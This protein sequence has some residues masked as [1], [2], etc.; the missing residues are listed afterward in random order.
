VESI[1][2]LAWLSLVR[3][4]PGREVDAI[5]Y[6]VSLE[7]TI[8]VYDREGSTP[9]NANEILE[10]HLDAVMDELVRL[11]AG[12]P[13]IELDLSDCR[14]RFAILVEADDEAPAVGKASPTLRS[15]IHAAGG[16][17]PGRPETD[18]PAWGIERVRLTIEA[19]ELLAA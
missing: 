16:S 4:G 7:G 2:C 13:D 18:Q 17:T 6:V 8:A 19:V 15:A 11:D 5:H 9:A 12:D 3:L 10:A 1:V 14:V